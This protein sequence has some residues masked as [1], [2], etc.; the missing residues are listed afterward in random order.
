M[1]KSSTSAQIV[2]VFGFLKIDSGFGELGC[3]GPF[4]NH[5]GA[6]FRK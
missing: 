2:L 1:K 3:A 6:E 5:S 4:S